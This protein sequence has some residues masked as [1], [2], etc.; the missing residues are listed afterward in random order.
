MPGQGYDF[1]IVGAGSAGCVL[2]N[3]LSEEAGVRVLLLEAGGRDVNPLISIPIGMG[4]MHRHRMHIWGFESEPEGTLGGRRLDAMRGKVL[5]GSSSINVMAYTRGNPEDYQRWR[6][7]GAT[8]WGYADVLPYFRRSETWE[9]G[10]N[11]WRGRTGPLGTQY[12][13]TNDPIFTA[14]VD[15]G[16]AAGYPIV[17]DYNGPTQ[18]G[19]GKGQYTIKDGRRSSSSRAYLKPAA[20]RKNLKVKTH[21]RAHRVLFNGVRAV[22]VEYEKYGKIEIACASSEVLL[23]AGAFNSP[24]LLMLSGI[25][26]AAHLRE[27]GIVPRIDLPVGEGLQ[28]HFGTWI[29]YSRRTPG[30]FH[31][32]MR[33]DRM[34]VSMLR[35]YFFGSGPATVVPGGLHAFIKT[36]PS[37]E[38]PDIEFMFHAAPLEAKL[39]F[40]GLVRAYPDGYGIRPTLLHPRSQGT[41]RL[42]SSSPHDA[43]RIFFNPL[44]E[45]DDLRVL[46]E[47]FR[48]ARNVGMQKPLDQFRGSEVSP[49]DR[50]ISD[51]D[52]DAFIRATGT[53]AYHSVGTCKM[54]SDHRAVLDPE[55]RV[56][57]TSG[58]RVCDAS[59]MPDLVSGHVNAC[60]LMMA[61]KASDLICSTGATVK[62]A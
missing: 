23:A 61:E 48:R 7:N 62:K 38:V 15:S 53:N 50:V 9:E 60:V 17:E 37:L 57:G 14:W 10:A 41:V 2:A 28:D 20:S 43:V 16:K 49:G 5:G 30:R 12:A 36:D 47:G 33:F 8:G 1:I 21:A 35:A 18:E 25:G 3:R 51:A 27:M 19:F 56:R 29:S 39:W 6:R 54:G 22:G 24:Q 32:E 44:S 46:R 55:L 34:A 59:A 52:I 11:A 13:K 31:H 42:R 45:P 40:P 4:E 26:P 58:L